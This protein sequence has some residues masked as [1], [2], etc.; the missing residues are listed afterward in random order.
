M[1]I[2]AASNLKYASAAAGYLRQQ[3]SQPDDDFVKLVGRQIHDGS[4]TKAV[5]EQLRPAIQTALDAL[6]RERIE[7]R[8]SIA[9]RPE[10]VSTS[11][12]PVEAVGDDDVVTTDEEREGYMIVR[13]IAARSMAVERITMRDAKSYCAVL[14]DDNNRRP[15]CRLYFNSATT[16]NLGLF[17]ADKTEIKVRIDTP[18]DIYKHADA[19][20]AVIQSYL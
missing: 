16:K 2:E 18:S 6:I 20:E 11:P 19:I 1:I 3:L 4:I 7:D 5:T 10:A 12:H 14:C 15:I 8:L 17:S 13:A 9:L